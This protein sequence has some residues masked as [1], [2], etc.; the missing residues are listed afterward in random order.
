MIQASELRI[1]NYVELQDK[2]IYQIDSGHDIDELDS[3]PEG[4][5]Y[6]S[7]IPL[8]EEILL[9]LGAQKN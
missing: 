3:F 5:I 4:D 1:G 9:R 8:T 2:G 6:C 7:A